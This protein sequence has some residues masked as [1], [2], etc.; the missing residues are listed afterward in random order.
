[1]TIGGHKKKTKGHSL[2]LS[3][4]AANSVPPEPG[5]ANVI[6]APFNSSANKSKLKDHKKKN[7]TKGSS[8]SCKP[9]TAESYQLTDNLSTIGISESGAFP[10]GSFIIVEYRDK[11]HRVARVIDHSKL[12]S[13]SSNIALLLSQ[14]PGSSSTNTSTVST[15]Q[16]YIHYNDFNRRMDEWVDTKRIIGPAPPELCHDPHSLNNP[17]AASHETNNS[18]KSGKDE[19]HSTSMSTA[20]LKHSPSSSSQINTKS[21]VT[22]VSELEHDEHEGMDANSLIEHEEITKVKN[23]KTVLFGKYC[24]L[25][26]DVNYYIRMRYPFDIYIYYC[27]I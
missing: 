19:A 6:S 14:N 25:P 8:S 16:Y 20:S 10:I 3:S 26:H 22:T 17:S 18:C 5:T 27:T 12:P 13:Q 4:N 15:W 1:M 7:L 21:Q 2:P 11:S 24:C 23:F 9:S